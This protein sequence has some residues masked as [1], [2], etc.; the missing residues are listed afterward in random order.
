MEQVILATAFTATSGPSSP[1]GDTRGSLSAASRRRVSSRPQVEIEITLPWIQV[2]DRTLR[3]VIVL[4]AWLASR[5]WRSLC[6]F[7]RRLR[8]WLSGLWSL[9]VRNPTSEHLMRSPCGTEGA[10]QADA[11][12]A[13]QLA[14]RQSPMGYGSFPSKTEEELAPLGSSRIGKAASTTPERGRLQF[15]VATSPSETPLVSP[16]SPEPVSLYPSS[17]RGPAASQCSLCGNTL[18]EGDE[19]LSAPTCSDSIKVGW[20]G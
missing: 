20:K 18:R 3:R 9:F 5:I 8:S 15:F 17:L 10:E 2:T 6:R 13:G 19:V 11:L 14:P 7:F 4:P 16:S 1:C 12:E